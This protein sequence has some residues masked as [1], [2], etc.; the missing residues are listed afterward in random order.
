[1]SPKKTLLSFDDVI[2]GVEGADFTQQLN[3]IHLYTTRLAATKKE[4]EAGHLFINGKHVP[5]GGVSRYE[6][7]SLMLSTGLRSCNQRSA[8]SLDIFRNRYGSSPGIADGRSTLAARRRTY[9]ACSMTSLA[10]PC[11]GVG[12]SFQA[13]VTTSFKLLVS[14]MLLQA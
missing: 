2:A 10:L 11:G 12:L 4:S 7:P 13:L 1:M 6:R 14:S 9:R 8:A 5:L 3:N